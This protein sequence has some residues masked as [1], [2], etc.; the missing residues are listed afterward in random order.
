MT[1]NIRV[2]QAD[3]QSDDSLML[4]IEQIPR[5]ADMRSDLLQTNLDP[6]AQV[7]PCRTIPDLDLDDLA[8]LGDLDLPAWDLH[9]LD[10]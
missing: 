6:S 1:T 5:S 2:N 10:L 3:L 9:D 7:P 4:R 8:D